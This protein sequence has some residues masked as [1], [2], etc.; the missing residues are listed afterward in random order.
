MTGLHWVGS[1]KIF[2]DS[3]VLVPDTKGRVV[4]KRKRTKN[5]EKRALTF[6]RRTK[7]DGELKRGRVENDWAG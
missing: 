2:Q 3:F 7:D 4:G 6:L 1:G 5:N